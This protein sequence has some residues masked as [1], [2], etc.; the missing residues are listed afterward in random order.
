MFALLSCQNSGAYGS[1]WEVTT[2][3]TYPTTQGAEISG[4]YKRYALQYLFH[5]ETVTCFVTLYFR[6]TQQKCVALC[7]FMSIVL[8][9]SVYRIECNISKGKGKDPYTVLD[10]APL[11]SE[12]P[13][14]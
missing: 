1:A 7:V 13:P 8:D 11:R 9:R 10:I 5:R 14:Q 2:V 12:S 3:P 4:A 6:G